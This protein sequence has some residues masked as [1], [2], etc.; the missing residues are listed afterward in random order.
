[1]EML[2]YIQ[3]TPKVLRENI[4]RAKELTDGLVQDFLETD[5]GEVTIVASGSSY[6][7]SMMAQEFMTRS[8]RENVHVITPELFVLT[9]QDNASK[10]FVLFVSQS[11]ASTNILKALKVAKQAGLKTRLLT[12]NLKSEAAGVADESID[13]GIGHETVGFVTLGMSGLVLFLSMFSLEVEEERQEEIQTYTLKSLE[14]MLDSMSRVFNTS[15][16]FFES[17]EMSL[18]EMGPVLINGNGTDLAS[19]REGAL[20]FQE[21]LKLPTMHYEIEEFMHGP[22]IQLTPKYTVFLIDNPLPSERI[23]DIFTGLETVTSRAFLITNGKY[24]NENVI[25][26]PASPVRE[27]NSLLTVIPFQVICAKL[28]PLLDIEKPHPFADRF[29]KAV[30]TK[31]YSQH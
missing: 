5:P 22:D 1:M 19:A 30:P 23:H 26:I 18:A 27:L 2:D 7:A 10:Q 25:S 4:G 29:M 3:T 6:N 14:Q 9:L 24:E 17:H 20:K 28:M 21:T 31:D 8:L 16:D 12:S 11:G 15:I 13:Y